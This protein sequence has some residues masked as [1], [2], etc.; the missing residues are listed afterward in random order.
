M[1]LLMGFHYCYNPLRTT[2][3]FAISDFSINCIK[4]SPMLELLDY[5]AYVLQF[6][7]S[8]LVHNRGSITF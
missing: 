3:I 1:I 7:M 8:L 5:R 6:S 4:K 2:E